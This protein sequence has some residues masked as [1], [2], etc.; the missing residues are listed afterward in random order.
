LITPKQGKR[1]TK[2]LLVFYTVPSPRGAL[3]GLT[4]P[5]KVP[6]PPKLKYE[7]LHISGIMVKFECEAPLART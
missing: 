7:T 1:K 3:V 2:R 6:I 5:D 4:L